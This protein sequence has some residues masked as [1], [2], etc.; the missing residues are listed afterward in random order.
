[1]G[2]TIRHNLVRRGL[3]TA[4]LRWSLLILVLITLHLALMTTEHHE[5]M[6]DALHGEAGALFAMSADLAPMPSAP[7]DDHNV[8][9]NTL[10]GCPVGVAILPLLLALLAVASVLFSRHATFLAACQQ[11]RRFD[12][13]LIPP[14]LAAP[15]R[16]ALLQVFLI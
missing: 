16:R 2:I 9:R 1:M 12:R 7:H 14:S 11:L 13:I 15:Q 5:A 4:F 8:P 6:G 3:S 10:D